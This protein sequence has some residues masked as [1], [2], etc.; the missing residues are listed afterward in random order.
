MD[1]VGVNK[2]GV[3]LVVMPDLEGKMGKDDKQRAKGRRQ[4]SYFGSHH[5]MK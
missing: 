5:E 4:R 1:E 2:G 3:P